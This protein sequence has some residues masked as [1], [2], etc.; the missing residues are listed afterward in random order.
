MSGSCWFVVFV[1]CFGVL[2]Y[3]R[4]SL[5]VW[6]ISYAILMVLMTC[7]SPVGWFGLTIFW[8]LFLTLFTLLNVLPWRRRILSS[9]ILN[10]YKKVMPTMSRTEREALAAGSVTWEGELF[11]GAPR[12]DKFLKLAKPSLTTEEEAFINGPVEQLCAMINDWNITH[13]LADMPPEMWQFVK[14]QG[15]FSLII[16][17]SYGGKEFSAY[18]HSQILTKIYGIS[19]SV[20]SVVAVPNS[21]GP[22][23]LL[24]RYGTEEQKNYY[25]PRLAR[26]EDVPCFALTGPDAGSD[27]GAM[28]DTGEIC[29]GLYMG[30][31]VLGIRLNFSKRYITLAPVATVIGLAFKLLDPDHLLGDK[32][33]LGITCALI[34]RDTPNMEIGR[35]HFPLNIVFQNGPIH[36]KNVF[37]PIDFIIGG[38]KMAGQGWRMLMECLAAGR[39]ISLPASSNGGSKVMTYATGAYARIRRQF[40]VPIGLFEGV[41]AVVGRIAG[42]TYMIDSAR[43]FVVAA[44]D[45]GEH[46]AIASAIIK[47]HTTEMGRKVA[48]DAMDVHGGKGICLGPNNYLGRGYEAVPIAI[49]VEGANILTRSMIIFGQGAMRCH[50][51]IFTEFQAAQEPDQQKS[52]VAFDKAINAHMSFTISNIVRSLWLSLTCGLLTRAPAGKTKRYYQQITR[53]S[54][55]FALVADMSLIVIG[56]ALKRRENIS[57]RLGDIL[58]YLYLMS[59]TLKH[60]YDQGSPADDFP[61]VRYA[62]ESY[63]YEIQQAFADFFQNFPNKIVSFILRIIIFPFGKNFRKSNDK[64]VGELAKLIM[65]PTDSRARITAGIYT[66]ATEHNVVAHV[67]DALEKSILSEPVEKILQQAMRDKIISGMTLMDQAAAALKQLIISKDQ[68]NLVMQAETAR[69]LVIA[70]DDFDP[71]ELARVPV[72]NE[73]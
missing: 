65:S 25:L 56:G 11:K 58:S 69:H 62:C 60:Y 55:A 6:T 72:S 68:F 28:P 15:F 37:I 71:S 59:A 40:N 47:Y 43:S 24:L 36:G 3:N 39:A 67:Q 10:F 70:V 31:K 38:P 12:W 64:L 63:L 53:F 35:R 14:E 33:N 8:L 16:P 51:Y 57:A 30:K 50:P 26:G 9:R 32:E 34:P 44:I 41:E 48:N 18:A 20:A 23:E 52:L 2:S 29:N 66:A 61:L 4:A 17:K 22:G 49:T 45:T 46:P 5:I 21:L 27:A 73:K 7:L 1:I 19:A 13:N 42:H 54:A